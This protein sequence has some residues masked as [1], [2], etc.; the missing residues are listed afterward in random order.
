MRIGP[1]KSVRDLMLSLCVSLFDGRRVRTCTY[2]PQETPILA[3]LDYQS[4]G[5]VMSC[6]LTLS[7]KSVRT[8]QEHVQRRVHVPVYTARHRRPFRT[9]A[10]SYAPNFFPHEL[11][12]KLHNQNNMHRPN[13]RDHA[14]G[15]AIFLDRCVQAAHVKPCTAHH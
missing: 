10:L 6:L 2:V 7:R 15:Q 8:A 9:S 13:S 11:A 3:R 5:T 12:T 4:L 14:E 1:K